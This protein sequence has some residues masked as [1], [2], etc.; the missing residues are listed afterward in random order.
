MQSPQNPHK[1]DDKTNIFVALK[2]T[3]YHSKLQ[4]I[5][6]DQIQKIK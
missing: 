4:N 1:K 3:Y 5:L 2:K 6:D